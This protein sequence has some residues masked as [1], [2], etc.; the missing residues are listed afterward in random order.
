MVRINWF[1]LWPKRCGSK[2]RLEPSTMNLLV[3]PYT[4]VR[5]FYIRFFWVVLPVVITG[6]LRVLCSHYRNTVPG[7]PGPR[8]QVLVAGSIYRRYVQISLALSSDWDFPFSFLYY[9]V[10]LH[11]EQ[12]SRWKKQKHPLS[13]LVVNHDT[14]SGK[15]SY[16][17]KNNINTFLVPPHFWQ[18][19]ILLHPRIWRIVGF[20]LQTLNIWKNAQQGKH[21]ILDHHSWSSI[22][23]MA[24]CQCVVHITSQPVALSSISKSSSKASIVVTVAVTS[25]TVLLLSMK[26]WCFR[27]FETSFCQFLTFFGLWS[28]VQNQRKA[29]HSCCPEHQAIRAG[30]KNVACCCCAAGC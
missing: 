18:L 17:H 14:Y 13:S 11:G 29:A 8:P 22:L 20:K 9:A 10:A 3:L 21:V 12:T 19:P 15:N 5:Y 24:N 16:Y 7:T 6:I 30:G 4:G 25:S 2:L 27:R 26:Q 23:K 28:A 1:V